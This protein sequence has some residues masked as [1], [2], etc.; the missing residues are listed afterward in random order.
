M[1][2]ATGHCAF[3]KEQGMY[4]FIDLIILIIQDRMHCWSN[5]NL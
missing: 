1:A 3:L 4:V 5:D 2:A